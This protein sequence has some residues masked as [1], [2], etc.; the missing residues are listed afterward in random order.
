MA[1]FDGVGLRRVAAAERVAME[2]AKVM[3]ARE[4]T[5]PLHTTH[6]AQ[7][8]SSWI[9]VK[10]ENGE[11]YY[12]NAAQKE[13]VWDEPDSCKVVWNATECNGRFFPLVPPPAP[14][15]FPPTCVVV[16]MPLCDWFPQNSSFPLVPHEFSK[17]PSSVLCK[18]PLS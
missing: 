5:S 12:W 8:M 16:R 18:F 4:D 15:W 2:F 6:D 1:P 9:R 13:S 7:F 3:K 10:P 14:P 17:F 11:M